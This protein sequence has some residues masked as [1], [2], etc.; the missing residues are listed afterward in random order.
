MHVRKKNLLERRK[1]Q[2]TSSDALEGST[3][4]IYENPR[5]SV[6]GEDVSS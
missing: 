2:A 4:C 5:L 6:D 1:V 3:A